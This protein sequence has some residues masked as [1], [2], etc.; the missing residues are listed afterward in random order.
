L[1]IY[2]FSQSLGYISSNSDY[3]QACIEQILR[4]SFCSN[5]YICTRMIGQKEINNYKRVGIGAE[6]LVGIP[7]YF[8]DNQSLESSVKAEEKL[9]E[10]KNILQCT[11]VSYRDSEIWLIKDGYVIASILLDETDK[12]YLWAVC[13]YSCAKLLRMEVYTDGISYMNSYITAT[14]EQGLYAKITKRTFY[15]KDGSVAYDQIFEGEKEWFLFPDGRLCTKSQMME[16]FIRTLN[17]SEDDVILLDESVPNELLR[18][19]FMFGKVARLVALVRV[20]NGSADGGENEMVFSRGSYYDWF[21][22]MEMLDTIVVSTEEQKKDLLEELETYHYNIPIIKVAPIEGEFVSAGVVKSPDGNLVL[23][24]EFK[25]KPD[26]ILIYNE[27]GTW[28][29][30]TRNVEQSCFLLKGYEKKDGFIL[31]AY[32]DTARG[33]T[34]IAE[35][36]R[37]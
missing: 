33:K 19:V 8:T 16:E 26:G 25:G 12:N 7:Q 1:T 31:K 20:N 10:L 28:I 23:S 21:P 32:I 5:K 18:A 37:F 9:E 13:Y 6:Q 15:N 35:S 36:E 3:K 14:S 2:I 4:A 27:L 34:T 17:L 30:E 29:G 22:Y 11:E 24:W